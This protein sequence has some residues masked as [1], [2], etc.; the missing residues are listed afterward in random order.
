MKIVPANVHLMLA[1][2]VRQASEGAHRKVLI[3]ELCGVDID[4]ASVGM[5]W[6]LACAPRRAMA[7]VVRTNGAAAWAGA[8]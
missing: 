3:R 5:S 1:D 6:V 7:V 4:D 8:D 2:A